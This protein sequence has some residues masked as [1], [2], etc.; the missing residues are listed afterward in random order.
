MK[1]SYNWLCDFLDLKSAGRSADHVAPTLAA[2]GFALEG[3]ERPGE[4]V[5]YD[6]EIPA[7]RPDCLN[8]RGIARELAAHYG[9][10]LE[11]PDL[12]PPTGRTQEISASVGIL[13]PALCPRYTAR[14]IENVTIGRSPDWPTV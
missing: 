3:L 12:T 1:V 9:T 2:V 6:L 13:E 8:H 5:V 10:T 11:L 14:L 4:D 7:N